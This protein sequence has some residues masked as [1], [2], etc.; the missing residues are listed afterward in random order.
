MFPFSSLL[1]ERKF[2]FLNNSTVFEGDCDFENGFCDWREGGL[3]Q[4]DFDWSINNGPTSSQETGPQV[5]HTTYS[6]KGMFDIRVT[7]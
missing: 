5:D 1:F 2:W 3:Y 6:D 4:D 7:F